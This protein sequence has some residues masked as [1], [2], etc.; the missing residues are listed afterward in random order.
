MD[1]LAAH[2]LT[3]GI[4]VSMG[5]LQPCSCPLALSGPGKVLLYS[6]CLSEVMLSHDRKPD[7]S[8]GAQ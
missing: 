4:R 3:L 1:G 2:P 7:A 8:L 6:P 5:F